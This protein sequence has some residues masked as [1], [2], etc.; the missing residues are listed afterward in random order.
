MNLATDNRQKVH[1]NILCFVIGFK[2]TNLLLC[3]CTV[4][5][6]DDDDNLTNY[7]VMK[8]KGWEKNSTNY[9]SIVH[10]FTEFWMHRIVKF[11]E[12][13]LQW[14]TTTTQSVWFVCWSV[15]CTIASICCIDIAQ[16]K[17]FIYIHMQCITATVF[18][19]CWTSNMRQK[20]K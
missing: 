1:T 9:S 2:H 12:N 17:Y 8:K 18:W 6:V 4:S 7:Y 5:P 14:C 20:Y 3:N 13:C 11:C 16:S 15:Y 10:D 19:F